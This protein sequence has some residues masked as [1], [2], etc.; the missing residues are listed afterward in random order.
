MRLVV[1][2]AQLASKLPEA[3]AVLSLARRL[4]SQH[5]DAAMLELARLLLPAGLAE[6]CMP[7]VRALR[8]L[9][10]APSPA[11]AVSEARQAIRAL[12]EHKD[13]TAAVGRV[14]PRLTRVQRLR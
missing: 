12:L 2:L 8:A 6:R 4:H 3:N 9:Q 11:A 10:A 5:D 1:Q 14:D 7:L 13:W